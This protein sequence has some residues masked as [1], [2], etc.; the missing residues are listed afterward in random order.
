MLRFMLDT[1]ICAYVIK[2]YPAQL[3]SRFDRLA[4]HLCI[5]AIS[6]CELHYGAENSA[7]REQNLEEIELF[8]SRIVVLPL[9][10]KAASHYGQ[11]RAYLRRAGT[12]LGAND[13][14]IA[15]H[16]LSEDLTL[17]TNNRREFDRVPGLRVENW[18]EA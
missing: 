13:L 10:P 1:N 2:N 7:R 18:V 16:A 5:S 17:V 4:P 12:P 11:L 8:R 9:E 14:L 6:L 15:A 3:R